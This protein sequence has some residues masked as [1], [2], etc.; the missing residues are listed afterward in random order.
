MIKT[1][2]AKDAQQ[3]ALLHKQGMPNDFL[4]SFGILFLTLLHQELIS[5]P[6]VIALGEFNQDRL[7][8]ILIA[9]TNTSNTMRQIY[10]KNAF[11]FIFFVLKSLMQAPKKM[12]YLFQTLWYHNPTN[13]NAEILILT[14]DKKHR[15]KGI[16]SKLF[17]KLTQEYRARN[18][19]IA[20][21][22]TR[23]DNVIANA[24]YQKMGGSLESTY[25]I[26]D[27]VWNVYQYRLA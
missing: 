12:S 14:I 1:L 20:S 16:G 4:P 18:I 3:S 15:G 11:K 23:K 22:G 25:N 10:L 17:R 19:S 7:I 27:R 8:G 13:I 24:F 2:T 9:T 21:V 6:R 5:N 26:Y